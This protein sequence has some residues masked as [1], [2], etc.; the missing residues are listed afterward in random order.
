MNYQE[1]F[2]LAD[3]VGFGLSSNVAAAIAMA[4][5][6]GNPNAHNSVAPDDSYGLWQINMRGKLGPDRRKRFKIADNKALFDPKINARAAFTIYSDAGN[7]FS[8]W[9]TYTRDTYKKYLKQDLG[10]VGEAG[11][12][13]KDAAG[14]VKDAVPNAINAFGQTLFKTTSNLTGIAI[15]GILLTLGVIILLRSQISSAAKTLV[16]VTPGGK[17]GK[18]AGKVGKVL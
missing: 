7:S 12:A 11:D 5:S 15:A 16:K 6:G 17:V 8:P 18:V 1:L 2:D 13:I 10:H 3:S 4:E 14:D 9:T